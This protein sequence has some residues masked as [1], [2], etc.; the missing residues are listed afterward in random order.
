MSEKAPKQY[1]VGDDLKIYENPSIDL[2]RYYTIQCL[3]KK[4]IKVMRS[5][6]SKHGNNGTI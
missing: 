2:D 4:D 6:M 3:K 5:F 1:L